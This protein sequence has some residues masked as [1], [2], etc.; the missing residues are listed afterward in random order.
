MLDLVEA[1][2]ARREASDPDAATVLRGL[3]APQKSLPSHL[4][5]DARGSALFEEITRLEEY[6]PTRV[7]TAILDD[8]AP[9]IAS[10][11]P[12][13]AVL[14][15]YGSGSSRKTEILLERLPQLAAY[16]PIDVSRSALEEAKARL[17]R[18][19]PSLRVEP[20]LGDFAAPL[21]LPADLAMRPRLGFFP[22]S[23]IGNFTTPDA[24]DL[25]GRMAAGLGAGARLVIGADLLKD[26]SILIP[27]YDDARGVTAAF[28]LN[29]L[30][31]INREFAADFDRSR[32]RHEA[33]FNE[34]E[35]RVEMH[36]VSLRAQ[37]VTV[38][39]RMFSFTAGETIHTENS[40][41]YSMRGFHRLA[42]SAGWTPKRTWIDRAGLFSVHE[43]AAEVQDFAADGRVER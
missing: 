12:Q 20:T 4:F 24:R 31:R 10:R 3:S 15:E 19:F 17:A 23:T 13:G 26:P 29:M 34:A 7:E 39:G 37:R 30:E 18:R 21:R 11:T 41:K 8:A 1:V 22:G 14:V 2:A 32:F 38:L 25:L 28:N 6:Y 35:G 36:L 43:L 9:Q 27:A 16:A 33:R 5:Y 40:A 42:A